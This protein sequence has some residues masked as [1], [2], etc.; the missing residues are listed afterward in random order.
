RRLTVRG[1]LATKLHAILDRGTRRDFFDLY[2]VLQQQQLGIGECLSAMHEVYRG[3]RIDDTLL[4]RALTYFDDA[5]REAELP[6]EGPNDFA[7]IKEFFWVRV[8]NLLLPPA[9]PLDIQSRRVDV[10]EP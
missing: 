2:V 4:L 7:A 5:E 9:K 6:D 1:I 8:G 10:R 3:Q